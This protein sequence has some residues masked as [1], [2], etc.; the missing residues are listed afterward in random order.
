MRLHTPFGGILGRVCAQPCEGACERGKLDGAVH[1]R[2]LKRYLADTHPE[3][4]QRPGQAGPATGMNVAIVGSGPAGLMAAY[5]LRL[6]G[7]AVTVFESEDQP[8]G[9]LRYG[10]P[11]FRLP[12]AEVEAAVRLLQTMGTVFRTSE[13]IGKRIEWGR[14]IREYDAVDLGRRIGPAGSPRTER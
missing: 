10:V 3:I 7:H 9:L 2:A 6:K 11:A 1:I 8:G 12:V 5:D 14:L 13:P 4:A